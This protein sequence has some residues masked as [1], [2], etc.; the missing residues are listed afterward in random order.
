MTIIRLKHRALCASVMHV[1]SM[2]I[3][4]HEATC[5]L[6]VNH[7]GPHRGQ[8]LIWANSEAMIRQWAMDADPAKKKTFL[9]RK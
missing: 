1:K 2:G 9:L 6:P 8:G 5:K 7:E 4:M 3:I